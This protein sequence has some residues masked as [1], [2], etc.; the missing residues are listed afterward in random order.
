MFRMRRS[1]RLWS[2][3]K[4]GSAA[5]L[6]AMVLAALIPGGS[7]L[8]NSGEKPKIE[9]GLVPDAQY[10]DCEVNGTRYYR[11]SVDK[12]MEAAQTFN[13]QDIDFTVQTGDLIDRNLS[14]F[15]TMLP[16]YNMIEAPKYHVLGN[17]DFPVTTDE[18]VDLLDMPNQYYD[19]KYKNWRFVVLDTNDLSLYANPEG[20]EKYK[21]A[22]AMYDS[23]VED[24]AV[25]AQTWNGGLGNE[26]LSWLREVLSKAAKTNEKVVVIGHKPVYPENNH[27]VWNDE[28]VVEALEASGNVVAYFNG[29]NH[30]GNY[31]MKNGI[32]YVTLQGM[33]ETKDTNSY[34]IVQVYKDRLEIDGYGREADRVLNIED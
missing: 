17:H 26:Q 25:N 14:S 15:S 28:E 27:N 8:A 30:A 33:V 5:I 1:K 13:E 4:E 29:H 22:E 24:G 34:S 12:L 9:F 23:L 6:L 20:S 11:D 31:A 10:C 7:V 3:L 19:F 21:Q 32:H 18:V 2:K 16:I